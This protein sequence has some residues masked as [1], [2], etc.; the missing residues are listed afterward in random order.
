MQF[1]QPNLKCKLLHFKSAIYSL[2]PANSVT[3]LAKIFLYYMG[4]TTITWFFLKQ[5][6]EGAVIPKICMPQL[7]DAP[8]WIP[9]L[10]DIDPGLK[11]V[12]CITGT[13]LVNI[14]LL[15]YLQNSVVSSQAFI[16]LWKN[17]RINLMGKSRNPCS[18]VTSKGHTR[19]LQ[20]CK[21]T[22]PW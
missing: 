19:E 16:T 9:S 14:S 2:F 4:D 12:S 7:G 10:P 11:T 17:M 3:E 8:A 20:K 5:S 6:V 15:V 13:G 21:T 22:F 1:F 18:F